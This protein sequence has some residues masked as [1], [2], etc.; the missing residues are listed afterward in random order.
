MVFVSGSS[1]AP[2]H[3]PQLARPSAHLPGHA[4]PGST[5]PR[6]SGLFQPPPRCR[7]GIPCFGLQRCSLK[8]NGIG[9]GVTFVSWLSSY[10]GE[11]RLRCG[12]VSCGR[13]KGLPRG[14]FMLAQIGQS[15]QLRV[16]LGR[17]KH[18]TP[19]GANSRL[20]SRRGTNS[21][22]RP[23][24]RAHLRTPD[25]RTPPVP[26]AMHRDPHPRARR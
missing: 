19:P 4:S 9:G 25:R 17:L 3:I 8:Q 2:Q 5:R 7:G 16:H 6:F 21:R 15:S 20:H 14:D 1:L 24:T 23:R 26:T 18:S 13:R 10:Q 22:Q 12:D 11:P